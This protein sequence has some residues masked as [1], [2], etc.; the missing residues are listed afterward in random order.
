M[1]AFTGDYRT[2]YALDGGSSFGGGDYFGGDSGWGDYGGWGG[3][4][5]L[6]DLAGYYGGDLGGYPIGVYGDPFATE[7]LASLSDVPSGDV[8]S[9]DVIGVM[10]DLESSTIDTINKIE[11]ALRANDSPEGT[12]VIPYIQYPDLT[13]LDEIPLVPDI[14]LDPVTIIGDKEGIIPDLPDWT[15]TVIPDIPAAPAAPVPLLEEPPGIIP[16][17]PD[18]T[19]TV[20]PDIPAAPVA[21]VPLIPEPP[22]EPPG[23]PPGKPPGEPPG[24]P[25]GW[26]PPGWTPTPYVPVTPT[27]YVPGTPTPAPTPPTDHIYHPSYVNYADPGT[28][29]G[30][31]TYGTRPV[32]SEANLNMGADAVGEAI[33]Q[34]NLQNPNATITDQ[35]NYLRSMQMNPYDVQAAYGYS[36]YSPFAN[37][38]F[39]PLVNPFY[40]QADDQGA[41][42]QGADG[43]AS[44]GIASL[45]RR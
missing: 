41:G 35:L 40:Y 25:P 10:P 4:E 38:V 43:K 13:P 16:D 9:G 3:F 21:P 2:S 30:V 44:G 7:Y 12:T 15:P 26:E 29:F 34:W 6:G 37:P 32:Q 18:W 19:P 23:E 17:L 20:I 14:T 39:N 1:V 22:E 42:D 5:T 36:N 45:F 27:P 24:E 28:A 8:P 31:S 11:D 33:R